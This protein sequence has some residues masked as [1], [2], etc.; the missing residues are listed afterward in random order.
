[1]NVLHYIFSIAH[2]WSNSL[3][4]GRKYQCIY[5]ASIIGFILAFNLLTLYSIFF[6]TQAEISLGIIYPFV[7]LVTILSTSYFYCKN[8]RYKKI[9][10]D[11]STFKRSKANK[12][13]IISAFYIISSLLLFI[14]FYRITMNNLWN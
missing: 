2:G 11:V 9:L 12:L 14:Y 6:S 8:E 13:A 10:K 4:G 1:M 3:Y 7:G 5:P